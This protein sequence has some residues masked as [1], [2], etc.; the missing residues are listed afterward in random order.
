MSNK[1]NMF[2]NGCILEDYM[3]NYNNEHSEYIHLKKLYGQFINWRINHNKGLINNCVLKQKF[4]NWRYN[5]MLVDKHNNNTNSFKLELNKYADELWHK[6]PH[7]L[8]NKLLRKQK[9][10]HPKKIFDDYSYLPKAIDWRLKGYVTPVK[11]QGECGSCWTFSTTGAI[12]GL[13]VKSGKK[14]VSLS[15]S[16]IIDCDKWGNGC[17]GGTMDIG[18]KYVK[19]NGLETEYDYPYIPSNMKCEYN[20]KK[21]LYKIGGYIG[22]EGGELG[23]KKAVAENGPISVAIDASHHTFQ[24]YSNGIY[25][26]KDCSQTN[27]DHGVLVVGYNTTNNNDYWIVKNSWG[28]DWGN[29]GYIYMAMNKDNNCGIGTSPSY[30]II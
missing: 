17:S 16:Q 1:A 28:N 7:I 24:L 20:E 6:R 2:N 9:F 15:E 23:L 3:Y 18:F 19:L 12:E 29:N 22:V 11:N 13:L 5:K 27:L 10:K 8:Y 21:A 30:P 4:R 26:D 25:Y 14:L